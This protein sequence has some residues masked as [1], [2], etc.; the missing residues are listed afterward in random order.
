MVSS[1]GRFAWYEL[2]TPDV[3][4]A[5]AFYAE[6]IGW[7]AQDASVAGRAYTLFGTGTAALAGLMELPE[8]ARKMGG[9]A[10]WVGY[11]GV[12][13]VDATAD[14]I[15]QLGGTIYVPPTDIP[16]TSRFSVFADPQMATLA[17]FK[18][19]RAGH[20]QTNPLSGPGRIG[21]HELMA[22]DWEKVFPFY[23]AAFGWQKAEAHVGPSGTYQVFS[24]AGEPIGGM[25]SKPRTVAAPPF[26][27]YYF[28]VADIDAAARRVKAGGGRILL[29]PLEVPGSRWIV[30]CMDPQGAIFALE[31]ARGVGYFERTDKATPEERRWSW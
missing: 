11:V 7:S 8:A 25:V 28:N 4:A 22:D 3:A 1:H 23:S 2:V 9:T 19:Q 10:S 21:W 31:G 16:N 26:W 15:R 14:R 24:A 17:L 30:Q 20:E 5:R 12:D 6:V 27:L 18:W 29:G 13:D